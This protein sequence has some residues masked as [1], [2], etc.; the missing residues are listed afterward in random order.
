MNSHN[1]GTSNR[2]AVGARHDPGTGSAWPRGRGRVPV[3][4]TPSSLKTLDLVDHVEGCRSLLE[5]PCRVP[6]LVVPR[7]GSSSSSLR[8][9][10]LGSPGPQQLK[11]CRTIRSGGPP[12][13]RRRRPFRGD[14]FKAV[15][16]KPP[17][18]TPS[19]PRKD[20]RSTPPRFKVRCASERN[21]SESAWLRCSIKSS[22]KPTGK[23]LR[24]RMLVTNSRTCRFPVR[25]SGCPR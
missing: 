7:A 15:S 25:A 3:I 22:V 13:L 20:T 17:C 1:I 8:P 5:A 21:I 6:W 14:P 16:V 10:S 24:K 4:F 2:V 23:T 19:R 18:R 9:R 12:C 11:D